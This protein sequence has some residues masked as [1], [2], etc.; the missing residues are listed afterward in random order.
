MTFPLGSANLLLLHC[1]LWCSRR[2]SLNKTT[3]TG[4]HWLG[5]AQPSAWPRHFISR[6]LSQNTY[7]RRCLDMPLYLPLCHAFSP[8]ANPTQRH[9]KIHRSD[10][11]RRQKH[12][13][14]QTLAKGSCQPILTSSGFASKVRAACKGCKTIWWNLQSPKHRSGAFSRAESRWLPLLDGPRSR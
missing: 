14:R 8:L 2:A 5:G 4:P 11:A 6:L 12:A 9:I 3:S 13:Q 7:R 1:E 10:K